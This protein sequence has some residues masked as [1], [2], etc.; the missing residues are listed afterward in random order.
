[1]VSKVRGFTVIELMVVVAIVGILAAIAVPSYQEYMLKSRRADGTAA[2]LKLQLAQ[3]KFRANCRF[4]A[5][6]LGNADGC[7][8]N[9]GASTLDFSATSDS[10]LYTIAITA[11]DGNSYTI[12]AD[13]KNRQA[14]DVSC[15]PIQFSYPD[16]A[17]TPAGCW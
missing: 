1:M 9:A 2:L 5:G 8:A 4:Y 15:D 11:A 14:V 3:E 13:P 12:T 17:K 7:G 6:A 10:D 16:G